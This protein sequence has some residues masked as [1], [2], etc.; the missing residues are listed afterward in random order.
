MKEQLR[1][2][3]KEKLNE[4]KVIKL[5]FPLLS[6]GFEKVLND[7]SSDLLKVTIYSQGFDISTTGTQLIGEYDNFKILTIMKPQIDDKNNLLVVGGILTTKRRTF[8]TECVDKVKDMENYIYNAIMSM[9]NSTILNNNDISVDSRIKMAINSIAEK[10][11]YHVCAKC[12][13]DVEEGKRMCSDCEKLYSMCNCCGTY[14]LTEDMY[15]VKGNYVCPSCINKDIKNVRVTDYSTKV[16]PIFFGSRNDRF[17]GVEIEVENEKATLGERNIMG[18]LE[19]YSDCSYYKYDGS[20]TNGFEWI[21]HPCTIDYHKENNAPLLSVLS[22]LGYGTSSGNCGLHIH[23][24]IKAFGTNRITMMNNVGKMIALAYKF[25]SELKRVSKRQRFKY[26]EPINNFTTSYLIQA[27]EL[28]TSQLRLNSRENIGYSTNKLV[29]SL[30][31]KYIATYL[32]NKENDRYR[33]INLCNA[34][35]VEFR[36]PQGTMSERDF[37]AYLQLYDIMID[38][39][40]SNEYDISELGFKEIFYGKYEE[41]DKLIDETI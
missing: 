1:K 12:G 36:L 25:E 6:I 10:E 39:A 22:K 4:N 17:Y 18:I 20:L 8:P 14:H 38:V 33:V 5:N 37:I 16:S 11:I 9:L 35:T 21:T 26:C 31:S 7:N 27:K 32:T 2:T 15:N 34:S 28:L 40:C 30:D 41:L 24:S 29:D 19:K 3:I 13:K 23:V